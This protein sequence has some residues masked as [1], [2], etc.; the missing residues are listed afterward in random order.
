MATAV[1]IVVIFVATVANAGEFCAASRA[2][3]VAGIDFFV[4]T[5]S[6]MASRALNL[7]EIVIAAAVTIIVIITIAAIAIVIELVVIL[8]ESAEIFVH[9]F[10]VVFEI[11]GVFLETGD[12]VCD[13]AKNVKNCGNYFIIAV[14]TFCKTFDV[15][16]FFRNVH[17]FEPL[18]HTAKEG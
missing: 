6:V 17:D 13:I 15:S 14:K 7:D 3:N 4:E 1:A 8:L 11:F 9:F 16:N 12:R 5:D 10:N 2:N 18:Y